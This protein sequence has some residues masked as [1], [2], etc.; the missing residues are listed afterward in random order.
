MEKYFSDGYV[1]NFY[2]WKKENSKLNSKIKESDNMR[3]Y[4]LSN[5]LPAKNNFLFL[6]IYFIESVHQWLRKVEDA[7]ETAINKVF[8]PKS[9]QNVKSNPDLAQ[10]SKNQDPYSGYKKFS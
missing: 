4:F 1:K 2:K 8:N 10:L 9:V 7:S 3:N 6:C 5:L